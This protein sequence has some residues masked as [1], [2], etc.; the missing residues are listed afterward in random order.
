MEV[1]VA[2]MDLLRAVRACKK[3]VPRKSDGTITLWVDA[4]KTLLCV[5]ASGK[6]FTIT[7]RVGLVKGTVASVG[8]VWV[9]AKSLYAAVAFIRKTDTEIVVR[10]AGDSLQFVYPDGMAAG[11]EILNSTG[12]ERG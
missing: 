11:I 2:G 3:V 8:E 10:T 12:P 1:T 7:R 4:A 6:D 5:E 9:R